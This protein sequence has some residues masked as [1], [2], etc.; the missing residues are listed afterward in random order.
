MAGPSATQTSANATYNAPAVT[1]NTSVQVRLTVT[2]TGTGT[3]AADGTSDDG[4]DTENFT[5]ANVAAV[6]TRHRFDLP[7]SNQHS[8]NPIRRN[9]QQRIIHHLDGL[10]TEPD[11]Y[12][13]SSGISVSQRTR[14]FSDGSFTSATVLGSGVPP[15]RAAVS[16]ADYSTPSGYTDDFV[17]LIEA[18]VSAAWL[19][20]S[21]TSVGTLLE[22]DLDL[23]DA[24]ITIQ[25]VGRRNSGATM[26][27]DPFRRRPH[28]YY[29]Q[30]GGDYDGARITI[31]TLDA[32]IEIDTPDDVQTAPSSASRLDLDVASGD[33][34]DFNAIGTGDRFILAIARPAAVAPT[35]QLCRGHLPRDAGS[36]EVAVTK[37]NDIEPTCRSYLPR[38]S[39]VSRSRSHRSFPLIHCI[40]FQ[41]GSVLCRVSSICRPG[42]DVGWPLVPRNFWRI[43]GKGINHHRP[44]SLSLGG[45]LPN[46]YRRTPNAFNP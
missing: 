41:F 4:T 45:T 5:V 24:D 26:R 34:A 10:R 20:R 14:S 32:T 30:H 6:T 39:R 15:H 36:L 7:T 17:A 21:D 33:Q 25:R 18:E 42:C 12:R 37:H 28:R 35:D 29:F 46:P 43:L 38:G 40:E 27:L 31:Q 19:F 8:F 11:S 9:W 23:D 1:S 13:D 2:A 44:V 22:G 16:L 3:L